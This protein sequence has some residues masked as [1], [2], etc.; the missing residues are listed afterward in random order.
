M[1]YPIHVGI[2]L[3]LLGCS[4]ASGP[5]IRTVELSFCAPTAWAG[6]QN[7]GGTFATIATGPGTV[8]V[9]A[10]RRV[11][12]GL[13][14][15]RVTGAPVELYYLTREQAEATFVCGD[16]VG[17]L[18]GTIAGAASLTA[19]VVGTRTV[20]PTPQSPNFTLTGLAAAPVDLV[21]VTSN[22]PRAIIR[23][24]MSYTDGGSIAVLDFA[25][26]EAFDLQE[27][28]LTMPAN[29]ELLS[30]QTA[31]V[32]AR[33]TRVVLGSRIRGGECCIEDRLR[34]VPAEQ[35]GAGDVQHLRVSGAFDSNGDVRFTDR[36]HGPPADQDVSFGPP[37]AA[38]S[39]TMLGGTDQFFRV[40]VPVQ[41]EYG[42]QIEVIVDGGFTGMTAVR[43]ILQASAEYR[44]SS[45][46][47][48]L[49][50]PKMSGS[51]VPEIPEP[52]T[53]ISTPNGLPWRFE[54]SPAVGAVYHGA[55]SRASLPP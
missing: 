15:A 4:D 27:N 5:A 54:R 18:S 14:R 28:D 39:V 32:T 46:T 43:W 22:E 2:I 20:N 52:H 10:G 34:V 40:E 31:L 6:L 9:D 1:R 23:H 21:A 29:V 16:G 41:P 42:G 8:K 38:A 49:T 33:G 48:S 7:D 11:V 44:G 30:W 50:A 45:P 37:A 19:V 3:C 35:L 24:A 55:I 36:F 17:Q 51:L 53:V 47:W 12:V 13:I 25:S 26:S